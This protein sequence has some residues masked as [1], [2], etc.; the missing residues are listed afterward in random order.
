MGIK[1]TKVKTSYS[2]C[3]L[4]VIGAMCKTGQD[5]GISNLRMM[6]NGLYKPDLYGAGGS[7]AAVV[8][9]TEA[10]YRQ[11]VRSNQREKV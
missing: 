11:I 5:I 2:D 8:G 9:L 1:G 6:E 3:W 4:L 10:A 7:S